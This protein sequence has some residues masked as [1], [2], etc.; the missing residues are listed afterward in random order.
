MTRYPD[1]CKG[2]KFVDVDFPDL[3]ERKSSIV[4]ETTE[5]N[6]V[7]SGIED[8]K[9]PF[10]FFESD[11]YVQIGCDLRQ[12][13]RIE[14]TLAT[15]I[16]IGASEFMFVAEV[17][18]TYMETQAADSVI[19]WA[20]SLS[21]AEFCLVEQI[22]PDGADNPFAETMVRHFDKLKT[23]LKSV[24]SYPSLGSQKDRFVHLGWSRV[25][26]ESLW[27]TWSS[28]TYLTP[29]DRCKLDEV[30]PFDEWEEFAIFGS[31]YCVV[32]AT[33]DPSTRGSH[34]VHL[35]P[36]PEMKCVASLTTVTDFSGS[37]KNSQ[38]RFGAP[39]TIENQFGQKLVA[40]VF[41]LGNT[42]RLTSVDLFTSNSTSRRLN[43]PSAGPSTRMCH[44]ILDLGVHGNLLVGGRGSP[45][46]P[47]KDCWLFDK[48]RRCWQ[49]VQD[50]PTPLYRHAATRLGRSSMA[51]VV[52]GKT[53]SSSVFSGCLLYQPDGGGWT[54]C[55]VSGP[56]PQP[57]FGAILENVDEELGTD[58]ASSTLIMY[59]GILAGGILQDGTVA[60]KALWWHLELSCEG[61]PVIRFRPLPESLS[62]TTG[63]LSRFGAST[64]VDGNGRLLVVGGIVENS[65]LPKEQEIVIIDTTGSNLKAV[66]AGPIVKAHGSIPRPLL[67]G[68]SVS[69]VDDE[70][71]VIMGGG[72]TCFSM[73]TYWNKGCYTLAYSLQHIGDGVTWNPPPMQKWQFHQ[74]SQITEGNTTN[75]DVVA[76]AQAIRPQVLQIPRVRLGS[77]DAF[78]EVMRSGRP[79]VI[80]QCDLGPCSQ[81]SSHHLVERIGEDRQVVVHEVATNKM[82]FNAKNFSYSTQTFGTFMR[83]VEQG[84]K[85]YLRALSEEQP[86]D[87]PTNL[88]RD[89]PGLADD[90]CLP[91]ELFF[92]SRNLFSSV[93]RVSGPVS[94]WL[95]FDVMANIYCQLVGSKRMILFP[96][97]D[98]TR[99]S[100][101][102]G[103]SSSSLDVFADLTSPL[104]A[105]THPHEAIL[106]P[107]DVLFLPPLWPH[108]AAP[109]TKLGVA[110][111]VFFRSLENG[112]SSGRDVYGNRDLAAYEKGRQDV[113]RIIK[114]FAR[115]PADMRGFYVKR[116]ADELSHACSST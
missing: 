46:N 84:A 80:E 23:P 12:L 65:V 52:G 29:E 47:L 22:L 96:P 61:K 79:V 109:L 78:A 88:A 98:V 107:G 108:T 33:N 86:A 92:V 102:P 55:K 103:A 90:F 11:Q 76:E 95:H 28:E 17:S 41:G 4:K 73:G 113:A 75:V 35:S 15:V 19:R 14:Q 6:S 66:A 7:L 94:M 89:F 38:R 42:T 27:S 25:D 51:L 72:A 71:I 48:S 106:Q 99:L 68:M 101:A 36:N 112:Y 5:L 64:L 31:H 10:I 115:V 16:D 83:E 81:W 105:N 60:K 77:S 1:H 116:L 56:S 85:M 114:S 58:D 39:M 24:F 70:K 21:K 43:M 69:M 50:L 104:L 26:V 93:L 9:T 91:G 8:S 49:R 18:I 3:M 30:E 67:A 44:A 57:V 2:V 59:R 13:D 34:A 45:S 82:D 97:C 53:G 37:G 40:N 111:N 110:V 74:T 87:E 62:V 32:R 20:S 63:C 54:E 100:F